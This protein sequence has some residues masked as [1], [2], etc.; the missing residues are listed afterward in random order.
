[1]QNK[2]V[3]TIMSGVFCH[4]IYRV[5]YIHLERLNSLPKCLIC[6]SHSNVLDPTFIY[7]KT[8]DIYIMAKAEIF[9]NKWIAKLWKHYGVFPV[10]RQQ[11]DTKSVLYSLSLFENVPSR[12]LLIFPEGG[13]LQK[14]ETIGSRVKNG[15]VFIAAEAGVPI[16]PVYITRR[17]KLFSKVRVIFGEPIYVGKEVAKNKTELRERSKQL[18]QTIYDL[19]KEQGGN[20]DE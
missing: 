4:F 7:P 14:G 15:A 2:I 6:P 8:D 12:R 3:K 19:G 16:I 13:I 18:I 20:K 9:K 5:R 1:M 11:R 10:N 17:P